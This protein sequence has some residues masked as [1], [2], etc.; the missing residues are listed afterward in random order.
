[1]KFAAEHE[2][3]RAKFTGA[4]EE[5]MPEPVFDERLLEEEAREEKEKEA[6]EEER[7]RAKKERPAQIF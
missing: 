5:T 7:R 4:W 6:L 3:E 1:M 2:G